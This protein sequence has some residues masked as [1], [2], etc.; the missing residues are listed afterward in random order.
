MQAAGRGLMKWHHKDAPFEET[1]A[2]LKRLLNDLGFDVSDASFRFAQAHDDCWSCVFQDNSYPIRRSAGKGL[3]RQ[4]AEAG[5]LSEFIERL[6]CYQDR[7]FGRLGRIVREQRPADERMIRRDVLLRTLPG[8]MKDLCVENNQ[9]GPEAFACRPFA[10][11]FGG[12]VVH[13]PHDLM[14]D[15]TLSN[16]MCAGNTCEEAL[17][18]GISEIMERYALLQIHTGEMD[19]L[20]TIPMET[21]DLKTP[22]LKRLIKDLRGNNVKLILK[23]ATLEGRFPVLAVVMIDESERTFGISFGAHPDFEIA[24]ERCITETYQGNT[25]LRFDLDHFP[26]WKG[27]YCDIINNRHF[28]WG[29]LSREVQATPYNQAFF[30]GRGNN[31]RYLKFLLTKLRGAGC[32]VFVQDCSIFGFPSYYVYI[33]KLSPVLRY[34][35][36]QRELLLSGELEVFDL[37]TRLH[38]TGG[39]CIEKQAACL[40][41]RSEHWDLA[42]F[43]SHVQNLFRLSPCLRAWVDVRIVLSMVFFLAGRKKQARAVL[44]ARVEDLK[45]HRYLA[46]ESL[47]RC[48]R[49]VLNDS[50][51]DTGKAALFSKSNDPM[52]TLLE[53]VGGQMAGGD[54]NPFQDLPIPRCR[55]ILCCFDCPCRVHC[56][57]KKWLSL[58]KNMLSKRRDVDPV[59]IVHKFGQWMQ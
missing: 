50:V 6:Q 41:D 3:C 2:V 51:P 8:I 31:R 54:A 20:P 22:A 27:G 25:R 12:R 38:G 57:I 40:A 5:A 24:L 28:L 1:L 18:Q 52:D 30:E 10:D 55:G 47:R 46:D 34:T 49:D 17:V 15:V 4:S 11:L 21:L 44:D 56:Y 36:S 39:A 48:L 37:I 23:D 35:A 16:G 43:C 26:E 9:D 45:G 59:H 29:P 53:A 7:V 13:A 32:P 19:A 14:R 58:R 42:L 33:E